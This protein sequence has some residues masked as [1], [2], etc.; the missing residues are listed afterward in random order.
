MSK[1]SLPACLLF[2]SCKHMVFCALYMGFVVHKLGLAVEEGV[3]R[4]INLALVFGEEEF[5]IVSTWV[6]EA[7]VLAV[8]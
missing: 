5:L 1:T 4:R 6:K 3:L 8:V 7:D 2:L